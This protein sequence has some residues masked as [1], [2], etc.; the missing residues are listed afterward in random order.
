M[1][2]EVSPTPLSVLPEEVAELK[3]AATQVELTE[4]IG[5][6]LGGG[7]LLEF[8][9]REF[10]D[11]GVVLGFC[12]IDDLADLAH[13]LEPGSYAALVFPDGARLVK[14]EHDQ[15]KILKAHR[16]GARLDLSDVSIMTINREEANDREGSV[17]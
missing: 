16:A 8:A 11:H 2:G 17:L 15:V 10:V 6:I 14:F 4:L 13:A 12:E 9:Q 7:R 1:L 5:T 3:R